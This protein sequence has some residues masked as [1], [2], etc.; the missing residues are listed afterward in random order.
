MRVFNLL[1]PNGN[2]DN[3]ADIS[4]SKTTEISELRALTYPVIPLPSNCGLIRWIHGARPVHDIIRLRG[5]NTNFKRHS[6]PNNKSESKHI[7][8]N[9]NTNKT[10]KT[11]NA[12]CYHPSFP[13][14]GNNKPLVQAKYEQVNSEAF[15]KLTKEILY[16]E[17]YEKDLDSKSIPLDIKLKVFDTLSSRVDEGIISKELWLASNDLESFYVKRRGDHFILIFFFHC[18]LYKQQFVYKKAFSQSLATMS[19]I[20]YVLGLGDRHLG[21]ILLNFDTGK[22]VHI[23]YNVCFDKGARLK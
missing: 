8:P 15:A 4:I 13:F 1:L 17:G 20:G 7:N 12:Y 14:I 5:R 23:D 2:N 16:L 22:V 9:N 3:N 11:N 6:N 19:M 18:Y 10:N 21:N